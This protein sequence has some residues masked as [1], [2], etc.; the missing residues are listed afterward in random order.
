MPLFHSSNK[1]FWPIL[2]IIKGVKCDPFVNG[3]Y[4]GTHKPNPLDSFLEDFISEHQ[5][6]LARG[7]THNFEIHSFVMHLRT[8]I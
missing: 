7:I 2:G 3:I 1:Q 6:F 8:H 5:E 4:C